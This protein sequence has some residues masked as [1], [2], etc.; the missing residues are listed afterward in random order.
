MKANLVEPHP[1]AFI[2]GTRIKTW[3]Q[4]RQDSI[5]YGPV[6]AIALLLQYFACADQARS[7]APDISEV[8]RHLRPDINSYDVFTECKNRYMLTFETEPSADGPSSPRRGRG[9]GKV[10][11]L[12][13]ADAKERSS[14]YLQLYSN[15]VQGQPR[16]HRFEE[17]D[18]KSA[19][20]K[21]VLAFDGTI[22]R[23]LY[24]D[25]GRSDGLVDGP[26]DE[27][28]SHWQN[29]Y[30]AV[31]GF[32]DQQRRTSL[33]EEAAKRSP[34]TIE[35]R[36]ESPSSLMVD[37]PPLDKSNASSYGYRAWLRR[38]RG[39]AVEKWE[40]LVIGNPTDPLVQQYYLQE[41]ERDLNGGT[42][43]YIFMPV[44][45]AEVEKSDADRQLL[46]NSGSRYRVKAMRYS[47]CLKKAASWS[48]RC[49][50]AIWQAT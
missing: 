40:Q 8:L 31:L 21:S 47:P 19:S 34:E 5:H 25:D 2:A 17:F 13:E 44:S 30:R 12:A 49:R 9:G 18:T 1:F 33:H 35:V 32:T 38:D 6:A 7:A 37:L 29:D 39:W 48:G 23:S 3:P 22:R 14:S 27:Q 16:R 24:Y 36:E 11:I 28:F 4:R 41:H 42:L 20:L 45:A 43:N 26:A 46:L 50:F 10:K 15:L